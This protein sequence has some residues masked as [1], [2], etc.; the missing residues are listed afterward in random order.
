MATNH[1]IC[2]QRLA[3][4]YDE[5]TPIRADHGIHP[6]RPSNQKFTKITNTSG[7]YRTRATNQTTSSNHHLT[8]PRTH[9]QSKKYIT[10]LP[11]LLR[12]TEG[13]ARQKESIDDT[14]NNQ[15]SPKTIRSPKN[16]KGTI[17]SGVSA[18]AT[19]T[20]E[21]KR[22]PQCVPRQSADPIS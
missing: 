20:M 3:Q 21:T 13:L 8:R 6:S 11:P 16:F 9:D 2:A 12:R 10:T 4:F 19:Y 14:P 18:G 22:N 17:P 15:T 7:S 1:T 5:V